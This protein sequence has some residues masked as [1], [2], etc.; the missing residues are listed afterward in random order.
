MFR[1]AAFIVLMLLSSSVA[2]AERRVALVVGNASYTTSSLT[3][4]TVDA[5]IV[6]PAL[7][8]SGFTVTVRENVD[9]AAFADAV[10]EFIADAQGADVALFYYAGHGFS[11][12][13]DGSLAADTIL[14]STDAKL[15]SNSPA[16][17]RAGGLGLETIIRRM[18]RVARTTL[19][20]VDA[21]RNDP[22]ARSAGQAGDRVIRVRPDTEDAHNVFVGLSTQLGRTASDGKAGEGT[23]FARAFADSIVQPGLRIDDAFTRV[24]REV[25]KET[26]G[27]QVPQVAAIQL[28]DPPVL[29][30][31]KQVGPSADA[32][33]CLQ[34]SMPAATIAQLLDFDPTDVVESCRQAA[35]KG[36][37]PAIEVLRDI[38]EEQLSARAAMA[39]S[40]DGAASDYLQ[41]Y[42]GGR[43]SSAIREKIANHGMSE[44]SGA[45]DPASTV[46]T[47]ALLLEAADVGTTG[48]TPY[49]GTVSWT[50]ERDEVGQPAIVGKL[51]IPT[52]QVSAT[53]LIRKNADPNL[54][55]SHLME[56]NFVVSAD[57]VGGSIAG[58]PGIL[59]KN[60]ELVQ[61]APLVGASARVVENSFLFALSNAPE[62]VTANTSLMTSRS[63]MDLALIYGS[64]RRAIITLEKDEAARKL[65]D[66]VFSTWGA[67]PSTKTQSIGTQTPVDLGL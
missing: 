50:E 33:D 3:N 37:D 26:D 8:K 54:P 40:D 6:A 36:H 20:F 32:M 18:A 41:R 49:S 1:V 21:C 25:S 7:E 2:L 9:L 5:G 45:I 63:W 61:G 46:G 19:V 27:L 43:Y 51:V 64:G 17:L 57:F 58:L 66:S 42:P 39:S 53:L 23:P 34:R 10:D 11:V 31:P 47:Q 29:V 52:R 38:G 30:P 48:A 14:M 15:A 59:L 16:V 4:P 62:D 44:A 55:A 24:R 28:D 13:E 60:E 22:S 67:A 65:F 12:L 35:A 56:V